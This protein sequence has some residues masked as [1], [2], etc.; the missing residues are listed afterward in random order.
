MVTAAVFKYMY[1]SGL[2]SL[3]AVRVLRRVGSREIWV[4]ETRSHL[5]ERWLL[6]LAFLGFLAVPL[7]CVLSNALTFADCRLPASAGWTGAAVLVSA[8]WL[9][10]RSHAD[11]GRNWSQTLA[12]REGHQLITVGAYRRVRHPM[13]AAFWLFGIAQALLL[14][15]WIAGFSG[16]V[17]FAPLYY[18][19]VPREERM[20]LERFGREYEAYMIRTGRVLPRRPRGEA[21]R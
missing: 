3:F 18:L 8:L 14:Q 10:Q 19:R 4:A 20:M 13:Y 11:L 21:A 5:L 17:A 6:A 7:A 16:L 9:L 15:N 12:L 2:L 1:L